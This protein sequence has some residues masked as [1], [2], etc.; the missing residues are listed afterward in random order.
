MK[1]LLL[2][3][4]V[5]LIFPVFGKIIPIGTT[6]LI[7]KDGDQ[8]KNSYVTKQVNEVNLKAIDNTKGKLLNNFQK[9]L[10]QKLSKNKF[11]TVYNAESIVNKLRLSKNKSGFLNKL[12]DKPVDIQLI[13]PKINKDNM[14]L[15]SYQY[16]LLGWVESIVVD[17]DY[18]PIPDNPNVFSLL[19]NI[20][21]FVKYKVVNLLTEQVLA[22]FNAVGHA[23]VAHII[24]K[25]KFNVQYNIDSLIN[26]LMTDL[27]GKVE[28]GLLV[29]YN[30]GLLTRTVPVKGNNSHK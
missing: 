15:E 21:I 7:F 9:E 24:T 19:Y 6:S 23:G 12:S 28:H 13:S 17:E 18:R 4:F 2:V 20:D 8:A 16:V 11:F 10:N 30:D 5:I 22:Q 1:K 27:A 14:E 29:Q 25:A 26:S 3:V